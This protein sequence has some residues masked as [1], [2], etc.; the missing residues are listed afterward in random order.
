MSD[1][2]T[3]PAGQGGAL[4]PAGERVDPGGQVSG[5]HVVVGVAQAGGG[6]LDLDLAGAGVLQLEVD[7]LVLAGGLPDNCAAGLHGVV[8]LC[9]GVVSG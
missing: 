4:V 9:L 7:D 2:D 8:L 6:K 5:G 1:I 3:T